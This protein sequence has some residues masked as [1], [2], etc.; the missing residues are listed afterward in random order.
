MG[1]WLS[2]LERAPDKRKVGGSSPLGPTKRLNLHEG[3][4]GEKVLMGTQTSIQ[5]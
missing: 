1:P 2:R 5:G 3:F 4:F